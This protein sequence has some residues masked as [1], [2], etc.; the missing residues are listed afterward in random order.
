MRISDWSSDVCS[1]DLAEAGDLRHSE[2]KYLTVFEVDRGAVDRE[3]ADDRVEQRGLAG[4][5]GA[6]EAGDL[7]ARHRQRDGAVGEHAADSLGHALHGNNR[8]D[9]IESTSCRERGCQY[10]STT[11]V[12]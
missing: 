6:G 11:E 4:A 9:Q 12:Y 1:S 7:A 10:G 8:L 2:R 3:V 5:V